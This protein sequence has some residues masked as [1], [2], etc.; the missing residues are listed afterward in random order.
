MHESRIEQNSG[1]KYLVCWYDTERCNWDEVIK[2]AI[3]KHKI[4]DK[5][6]ILCLP[7]KGLNCGSTA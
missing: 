5:V 1:Q 4:D 7:A 2:L 3:A 6:P